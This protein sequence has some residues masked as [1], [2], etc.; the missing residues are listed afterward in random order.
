MD[1]VRNHDVDHAQ[2]IVW[3]GRRRTPLWQHG[4]KPRQSNRCTGTA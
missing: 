4:F 1:T 3:L 2:G